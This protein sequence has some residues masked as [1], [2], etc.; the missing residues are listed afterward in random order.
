MKLIISLFIFGCNLFFM[1]HA[2]A[3][4]PF[5]F[6]NTKPAQLV[7]TGHYIF[8]TSTTTN[9]NLGGIA[10]GNSI[11]QTRA[12]AASLPGTWQAVLSSTASGDVASRIT[13]TGPLYNMA[14]QIISENTLSSNK[15]VPVKFNEFGAKSAAIWVHVGMNSAGFH[16]SEFTTSG[17]TSIGIGSP[18]ATSTSMLGAASS[19]CANSFPIYCVSDV[20]T[21]SAPARASVPNMHHT[22][23]RTSNAYNGNLGGIAGA[24]T[25]CQSEAVALGYAGT[26]IAA[27]STST[28][29]VLSRLTPVITSAG[30]KN[31]KGYIMSLDLAGLFLSYLP[32]SV[33]SVQINSW[34]GATNSGG[35]GGG[36]CADW[37]SSSSGASGVTG[38][39]ATY[40]SGFWTGGGLITCDQSRRLYCIS[41]TSL[42]PNHD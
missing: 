10:G 12:T 23:F 35:I 17:A 9:G 25:T 20:I 28:Q 31:S 22:M 36:H 37:T 7:R 32:A 3:F 14:G 34:T 30:V 27:L 29:S 40:G 15:Y 11:C 24:D 41:T 33:E 21:L 6:W 42:Q 38:T 4:G 5:S 19:T 39:G 16:C 8:I 18:N 26:Y 13:I 2:N 1:N